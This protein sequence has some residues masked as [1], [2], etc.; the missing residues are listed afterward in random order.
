M[1]PFRIVP[2]SA[3]TFPGHMTDGFVYAQRLGSAQQPKSGPIHPLLPTSGEIRS[4]ESIFPPSS[5]SER[6]DPKAYANQT[7]VENFSLDKNASRNSFFRPSSGSGSTFSASTAPVGLVKASGSAQPHSRMLGIGR[8][9]EEPEQPLVILRVRVISCS[10]LEAKDR[11]GYSD[12][13]VRLLL[14]LL[15]SLF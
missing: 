7:P 10:N 2:G 12:P 15:A 14:I 3:D 13:C 9:T 5:V 8:N 4:H 6:P 11:N 1:S